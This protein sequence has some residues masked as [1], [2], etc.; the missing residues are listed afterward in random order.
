MNVGWWWEGLKAHAGSH[1]FFRAEAATQH[2]LPPEYE[3]VSV[4]IHCFSV[5]RSHIIQKSGIYI[6]PARYGAGGYTLT[7]LRHTLAPNIKLSWILRGI[8]TEAGHT[9]VIKTHRSCFHR[10][11]V[12]S[13]SID[14]KT[15]NNEIW[16][17]VH[18][19][20][21]TFS[22]ND[23]NHLTSLTVLGS[24]CPARTVEATFVTFFTCKKK[25]KHVLTALINDE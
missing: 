15:S 5:F 25:Q 20:Q 12:T 16:N 19:V 11:I 18:N 1:A 7:W 17:F 14:F 2:I 6:G 3:C 10:P 23:R 21:P 13:Y 8:L 4:W 24:G 22:I 9:N